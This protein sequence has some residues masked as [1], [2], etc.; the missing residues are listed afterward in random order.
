MRTDCEYFH[1][2]DDGG[3]KRLVTVSGMDGLHRFADYPFLQIQIIGFRFW[4][5]KLMVCMVLQ[6]ILFYLIQI[7]E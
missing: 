1:E 7:L 4:N 3:H 6:I 2:S 5:K